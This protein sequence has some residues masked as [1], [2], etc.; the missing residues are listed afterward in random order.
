M[1]NPPGL[2]LGVKHLVE[3]NTQNART[4]YMQSMWRFIKDRIR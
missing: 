4:K 1:F 3:E 2:T